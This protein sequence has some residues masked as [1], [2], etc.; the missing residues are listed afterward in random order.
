[1]TE[2]ASALRPGGQQIVPRP[3][4][5]TIG[6]PAPWEPDAT[7]SL[8]EVLAAVPEHS[9]PLLP[10]FP[11]ARH[12][13]V[14]LT[15]ADGPHGP[16]VLLTRRSWELRHHRGEISF[17][18]GRM[19]PGE[20]PT[21]TALREAHEEVGLEPD[22]VDVRGELT[23]LSTVVSRSYIV[24]KVATVAERRELHGRTMEVDRV[25]WV[26]LR[27]L[28]RPD[29]YRSEVWGLGPVDRTLHFFHLD[30]ETVWGATARILVDLL[31]RC[32]P[33]AVPADA[34]GG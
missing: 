15:L 18:G 27:E 8:D 29:T 5:W 17:P 10:A 31:E 21:D 33:A 9:G 13:A 2:P 7:V 26:P 24:P 3:A 4:R 25:M 14:L 22:D 1:V 20:T 32:L 34:H 23:H 19:D 11:G 28:T 30:D 16:E 12:S 6:P